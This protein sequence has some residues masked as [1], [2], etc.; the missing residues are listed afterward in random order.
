[1]TEGLNPFEPPKSDDAPVRRKPRRVKTE[2][3]DLF[4]FDARPG[5]RFANCA[6]DTALYLMLASMFAP[7]DEVVAALLVQFVYYAGFETLFGKTPAK[8]LTRTRVITNAGNRP[9]FGH[10]FKRTL[11]RFVPFEALSFLGRG[12]GWHD[13]WSRTRVVLERRD[14]EASD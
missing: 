2:E 7:N 12:R 1:M 6:I 4:F 11:V 5:T 10:V 8:W 13:R 3:R 14:E 9:T